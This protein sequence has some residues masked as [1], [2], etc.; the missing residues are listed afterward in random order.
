VLAHPERYTYYHNDEATL[1]R[2]RDVG[3]LFQ[4]N[5]LSLTG[6]YGSKVR[7]Q[8]HRLLKNNW[9]DFIGSDMH[10]PEDLPSMKSL[11]HLS[12]YDLL[13]AQPLRNMSLL[14]SSVR[15]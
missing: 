2:I 4:L 6:R 10:R 8:A 9:V 3:C 1:A 5:W 12:E 15:D 7:S 13:R 14:A 11:F